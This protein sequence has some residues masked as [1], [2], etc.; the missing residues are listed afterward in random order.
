MLVAVCVALAAVPLYRDLGWLIVVSAVLALAG[1][2]ALTR[3]R[4]TAALVRARFGW[5]GA[6]PLRSVA[7]SGVLVALTVGAL[8]VAVVSGSV[9]LVCAALP[10]PHRDAL[11]FG[12][13]A[14]D[15]GLIVGALAAIVLAL[16]RGAA[17]KFRHAE[18][19]REPLF[20]L[21]WLEDARLPHLPDWQRRC[22][23]VRWRGGG[24]FSLV[25]VA[26]AGVPMGAAMFDVAGL[27]LLALALA[28]LAVVMRACAATTGA[29]GSLLGA[30]PL[31]S[32]RMRRASLRYP[33]AGWLGSMALAGLGAALLRGGFATWV[34]WCICAAA[35]SLRPWL[36]IVR[37]VPPGRSP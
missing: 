6:L 35:L 19:I 20:A 28:W 13:L 36:R 33:L 22:A 3:H 18:G 1:S 27:V 14:L 21:P 24:G 12:L 15:G 4:L 7:S 34:G 31:S 30:T 11:G 37:A 26:L 8:A 25:G 32:A 29:A 9:L 2:H 23:L 5:C 17:M 16:R 10:A